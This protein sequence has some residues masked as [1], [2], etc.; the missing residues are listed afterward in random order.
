MSSPSNPGAAFYERLCDSPEPESVD[1]SEMVQAA[2]KVS[3]VLMAAGLEHGFLGGFACRLLGNTRATGDVDI[4]V[5][6]TWLKIRAVLEQV[7]G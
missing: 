4:C 3:A 7:H 2:R 5:K 6:A 1:F